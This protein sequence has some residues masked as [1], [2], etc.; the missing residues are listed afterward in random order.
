MKRNLTLLALLLISGPFSVSYSQEEF[1][2]V[3][4]A[5]GRVT[6]T[7]TET[8]SIPTLFQRDEEGNLVYE[9]DPETNKTFKVPISTNTYTVDTYNSEEELVKSVET[10][11]VGTKNVTRRYGNRE[12]LIELKNAGVLGEE[13][14][15]ISGWSIVG[16]YEGLDYD[17]SAITE[18][19]ARLTPKFYARHT[20]K[21]IVEITDMVASLNLSNF[22]T[23][24]A[25][26]STTTTTPGPEEDIIR[27][28]NS[29]TSSY[30][31][32]VALTVPTGGSLTGVISGKESLITK[33]YTYW[34]YDYSDEESEK[35]IKYTGRSL[36]RVP[37]TVRME[38]LVGSMS[39]ENGTSLLEG[40][41]VI[42]TPVVVNGATY[43]AGPEED[44]EDF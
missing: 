22:M 6:A 19:N 13:V 34:D 11:E 5:A 2:P 8:W 27:S 15:S 30:K 31:G 20:D 33:T 41:V 40:S 39:Y 12:I 24:T 43:L 38:K 21:R 35:L 44:F 4:G 17:P 10:T 32:G 25:M 9:T 26:K 28:S 7:F 3:W 14:T 36:I 29:Y 1:E 37:G 42:S 23:T 16:Y 18:G